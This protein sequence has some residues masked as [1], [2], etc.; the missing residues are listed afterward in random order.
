MQISIIIPA[1]NEE[2]YIA[3][4]LKQI[5]EKYE[6]IV[7]CNGCTDKTEK[8]AKDFPVKI[9]STKK[10]G[11][12]FARNLGAQNATKERLVFM[13]ADI[14]VN[15]N[16]LE[17]IE[18]TKFSIGGTYLKPD[19]NNFYSGFYIFFKNF[20]AEWLHRL[21]G[22]IFCNKNLFQKTKGFD[23]NR[24]YKEDVVFGKKAIR[25]GN[26]GM[27]KKYGIVSMRRFEKVGY[28]KHIFMTPKTWFNK[29][30]DY[31]TVR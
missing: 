4:C 19:V 23:E 22:I 9:I 18:K 12:S 3:K 13:D 29:S 20:K 15:K 10:K 7:V 8:I 17:E 1:H 21:G 5:P 16:L 14:I 26:F 30:K 25:L 31:P 28:I 2:K 11:V 6:T 27:I 24:K